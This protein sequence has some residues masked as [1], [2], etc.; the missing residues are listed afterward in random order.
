MGIVAAVA[1]WAI[2]EQSRHTISVQWGAGRL[3]G[4][5]CFVWANSI[6]AAATAGGVYPAC[7]ARQSTPGLSR[8][9]PRDFRVS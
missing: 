1:P 7:S 9:Y 8:R 4:A 3:R 5:G 2:V 6:P